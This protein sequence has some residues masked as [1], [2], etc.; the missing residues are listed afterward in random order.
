MNKRHYV[1]CVAIT[2]L[3]QVSPYTELLVVLV[4]QNYDQTATC[5][6]LPTAGTLLTAVHPTPSPLLAV[7]LTLGNYWGALLHVHV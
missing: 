5:C 2:E 7:V 6:S 1:S 3:L 4:M